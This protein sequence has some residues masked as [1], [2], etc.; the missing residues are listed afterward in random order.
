MCS[1]RQ[2]IR[3]TEI[4]DELP[5]NDYFEYYGPDYR[6]HITP[7]N[8]ENRNDRNYLENIKD[9]LQKALHDLP[10]APSVPIE[11]GQASS[12]QTPKTITEHLETNED[13]ADPDKRD[14]Q[15]EEDKRQHPAEYYEGEKD[16]D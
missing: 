7:S 4:P 11:T 8:M 12:T 13:R 14:M 16:Q 1:V 5:Y 2:I 3:T 10:S 9:L 15:A 6:L